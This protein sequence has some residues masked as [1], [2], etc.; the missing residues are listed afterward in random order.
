M[1]NEIIV[2]MT[3]V[4]VKRNVDWEMNGRKGQS[5]SMHATVNGVLVKVKC[6]NSK[7]EFLDT[8][9]KS[10][11]KQ[12]DVIC[13]VVAGDNLAMGLRAVGIKSAK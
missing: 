4:A 3:P 6:D 13:E 7:V 9:E 11:N 8:V 5:A 12:I 10:L 2:P 1:K